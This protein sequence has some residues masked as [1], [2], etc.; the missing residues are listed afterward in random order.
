LPCVESTGRR[1]SCRGAEAERTDLDLFQR[2]PL[3]CLLES[4]RPARTLGEQ[5]DDAVL[6]EP[7]RGEGERLDRRSVE[8]LDVVDRDEERPVGRQRAKGRSGARRR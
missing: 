2:P 5:K 3:E 6:G 8:P 1:R 4:R 7:T